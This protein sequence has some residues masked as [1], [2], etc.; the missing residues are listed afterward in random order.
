MTCLNILDLYYF[1]N[2]YHLF[3]H[4]NKVSNKIHKKLAETNH[5]AIEKYSYYISFLVYSVLL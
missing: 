5:I 3:C 1:K 4:C 2:I